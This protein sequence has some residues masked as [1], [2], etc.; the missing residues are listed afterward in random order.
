MDQ[1]DD[2]DTRV[3]QEQQRVENAHKTAADDFK[4]LMS[5]PRGRRIASWLLDL[6]GV[7]RSSLP[8]DA[9]MPAREG[10][11]NVGLQIRLVLQ[12]HAPDMCVLMDQ[13][14]RMKRNA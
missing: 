13:E 9:N 10:A 1:I 6:T 7:F 3:A 2:I 4:W 8:N 5:S 11:R 12:E 14:K